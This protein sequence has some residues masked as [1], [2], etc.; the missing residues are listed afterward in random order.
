MKSDMRFLRHDGI[1]RPDVVKP[2]GEFHRCGASRWSALSSRVGRG[3]QTAP[4]SS[5]A[6]SSGRLFLDR[7][8][9]Q[10]CPSPFTGNSILKP[11]RGGAQ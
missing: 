11:F 8:A 7:V 2:F 10:H 9:R 6:M 5:S 4:L 3:L 1:F